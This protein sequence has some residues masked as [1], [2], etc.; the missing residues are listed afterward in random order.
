MDLVDLQEVIAIS[1]FRTDIQKVTYTN[2]TTSTISAEF[3]PDITDL[4]YES[5]SW[6]SWWWWSWSGFNS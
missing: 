2:D 4:V 6:I 3:I 5:F 1:G